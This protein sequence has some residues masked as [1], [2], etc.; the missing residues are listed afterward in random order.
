MSGPTSRPDLVLF[1]ARDALAVTLRLA[2][3]QPRPDDAR[4][5]WA[6][7]H[8]V[9][10]RELLAALAWSRSGLFIRRHA[11][12]EVSAAWRRAA[13][14]AHVRGEHQLELLDEAVHALTAAAIDVVVLKGLPLG[15]RLYHDAFVRCSADI[16]LYVPAAQRERAAMTLRWLGWRPVD[17][18]APWHQSWSMGRPEYHLELHSLLVS[19]HLAHVDAPAPL[20]GHETV[21]GVDLPVH[22]GDFVAPYLAVH[23]ATHQLPPL[24]WCVDFATLWRSMSEP[25][26]TRAEAAAH[27]A[28][29][30]RYLSW[31]R[32]QSA[33]IERVAADDWQALGLLGIDSARRRGTHSIWRHLTLAASTRDRLRLLG[34]FL[35][36]RRV[37]GSAGALVRYTIAR[38]RTRLRSVLG[39]SR[40]YGRPV[41]AGVMATEPDDRPMHALR[42]ER[43]EMVEL[44]RDVVG[45]GGDLYV[46][47]PGGSMLP[48]IARGALVRIGPLPAGGIV[49]GDV[50][51]ALTGDGEPVLH[52]AVVVRQDGVILRGDSAIVEDPLVP[53]S[54]VIGVATHARINGIEREIGRRPRRSIGISALKVRRHLARMVRRAR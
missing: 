11:T 4:A 52:R 50:V 7:V 33:L 17:G 42:L 20:V 12:A 3:G 21:A 49:A 41:L 15:E 8:D 18:L 43:D 54:R 44:T 25:A 38:L 14:S 53:F 47:A 46:R 23:L 24:L 39:A 9:A 2:F 29:L 36:P 48:T 16:D 1:D 34:A 35:V 45:A 5:D 22:V 51:L 32:E 26:R 10:S 31:A 30:D 37:R 19:D 6:L 13:M 40:D 27:T 28:R